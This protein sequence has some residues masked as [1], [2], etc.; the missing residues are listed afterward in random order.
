M[1]NDGCGPGRGE[2]VAIPAGPA[3]IGCLDTDTDCDP[4]EA[5]AR[6]VDLPAFTIDKYEVSLGE[7]ETWFNSFFPKAD[8]GALVVEMQTLA[9]YETLGG[10]P[11]S[12]WDYMWLPGRGFQVVLRPGVDPLLPVGSVTQYGAAMYC[13][14]HGGA[15]PT[16]A[17]WEKAARGGLDQPDMGARLYPMGDSLPASVL[18]HPDASVPVGSTPED[19]SPYRVFDMAGN[20]TEWTRDFY[21]RDTSELPDGTLWASQPRNMSYVGL[22]RSTR[23][24]S[25]TSDAADTRVSA[26]QPFREDGAERALRRPGSRPTFGF[27][28]VREAPSP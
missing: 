16:E 9:L 6:V 12:N 20:V 24:G 22:T 8:P 25:F 3:R 21:W 18:A 5:P 28:C 14:E 2:E 23:G 4:D 17:E 10:S 27:R 19:V 13:R 1:R 11:I 15:L 7:F 26:R